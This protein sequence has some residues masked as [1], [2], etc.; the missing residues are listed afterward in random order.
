MLAVNLKA[1][2]LKLKTSKFLGSKIE[3]LILGV[4]L[5]GLLWTMFSHF[6][7]AKSHLPSGVVTE[8]VFEVD[9]YLPDGFVLFPLEFENQAALDP[10]ISDFAIVNIYQTEGLEGRRGKLV[11]K[12]VKIMRAP[13]N[14]QMLAALIPENQVGEMMKDSG[15]FYGVLQKKDAGRQFQKAAVKKTAK[16]QTEIRFESFEN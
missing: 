5:L 7:P 9:A 8:E 1:L 16:S 10:L 3:N 6:V 4:L 2:I 15:A 14:P 13:Q 12:N 11:A